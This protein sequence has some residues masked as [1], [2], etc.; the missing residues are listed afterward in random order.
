[1]MRDLC[2]GKNTSAIPLEANLENPV[3]AIGRIFAMLRSIGRSNSRVGNALTIDERIS[4]GPKKMLF[5]VNC[6]DKQFLIATG[7][8]T[9]TSVIEVSSPEGRP[10][11]A[12]NSR[13]SPLTKL[14]KRER[15]P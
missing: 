15:L 8:D 12:P 5:L 4:L 3:S 11:A 10:E 1:M 7:A 9:I 6:M 13:K 14:Q 2:I